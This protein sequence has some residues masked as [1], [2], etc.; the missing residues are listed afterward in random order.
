MVHGHTHLADYR[1]GNFTRVEAGRTYV[2]DGFSPVRGAA[3]PVVINGGAWQRT[4]TPRQLDEYRRRRGVSDAELL[5]SLRPEQ[6]P[7]C[8]GFV[9]IDPYAERPDPPVL[10]YWRQDRDGT[11]AMAPR[12]GRDISD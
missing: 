10:R 11:W 8:Y 5:E 12:C 1:Q 9:Q 6:L 2:V 4:A 7:P 3:T